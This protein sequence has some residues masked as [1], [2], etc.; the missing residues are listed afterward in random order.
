MN[1]NRETE[2]KDGTQNFTSV[3]L[4]QCRALAARLAEA[5][6]SLIAEFKE[7]FEIHERLVQLAV[8]EAEALAWETD[9]PHL[10]FPS[11][12]LEKVRVAANW[13]ERQQVIRRRDPAL[14]FAA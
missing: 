8:N 9:Y 10:L 5:K 6:E 1:A 13:N 14:A 3:C 7:T 12:A 2:G 11:L 4:E